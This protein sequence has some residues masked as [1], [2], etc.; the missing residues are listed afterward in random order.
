VFGLQ[1]GVGQLGGVIGPQIFL[2]K[3][4][5]DGY[6]VSYAVCTAT[7]AAGPFGCCLCW[8]LTHNL[9]WDIQRVR[10]E[11]NKANQEGKR[12]LKDDIRVYEERKVYS[13]KIGKG[14]DAV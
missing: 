11:R 7:I 8:Y 14:K 1:S 12:H 6:K 3:Y 5:K 4:A 13:K 10:Q 2:S 9:E